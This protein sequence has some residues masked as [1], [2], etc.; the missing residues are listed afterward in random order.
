MRMGHSKGHCPL[1]YDRKD[2]EARQEDIKHSLTCVDDRYF[3]FSPCDPRP[4]SNRKSGAPSIKIS[5]PSTAQPPS[6]NIKPQIARLYV[7]AVSFESF[8]GQLSIY[9]SFT[10]SPESCILPYRHFHLPLFLTKLVLQLRMH[11]T[12]I[13]MATMAN[14]ESNNSFRELIPE[15]ERLVGVWKNLGNSYMNFELITD[16]I[17]QKLV[18]LG[19]FGDNDLHGVSLKD[20]GR[21]VDIRNTI[22]E[23]NICSTRIYGEH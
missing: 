6:H 20:V 22:V 8:Q 3:C 13:D 11:A 21:L 5:S 19:T 12:R 1:D 16:L 17:T 23:F 4:S 2:N 9:L 14:P 10:A 18:G 15:L 7:T